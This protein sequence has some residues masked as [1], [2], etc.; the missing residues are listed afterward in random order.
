MAEEDLH[1]KIRELVPT[2]LL[3]KSRLIHYISRY[4]DDKRPCFSF[5]EVLFR[6]MEV[7]EV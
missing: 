1:N 4:K 7:N 3:H 5:F 6:I 2:E